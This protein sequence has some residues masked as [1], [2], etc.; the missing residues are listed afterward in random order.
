MRL[1]YRD[2]GFNKLDLEEIKLVIAVVGVF[3]TSIWILASIINIY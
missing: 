1:G 2:L 3:M